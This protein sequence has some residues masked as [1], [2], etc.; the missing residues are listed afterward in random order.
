MF[1]YRVSLN[2][3]IPLMIRDCPLIQKDVVLFLIL[4]WFLS[5]I[6]YLCAN[7]FLLPS[8]FCSIAI[9][10]IGVV[11]ITMQINW[12]ILLRTY[13]RAKDR[14]QSARL[15]VYKTMKSVYT[16]WNT[17]VSAING[18]LLFLFFCFMFYY[19]SPSLLQFW[20]IWIT[21]VGFIVC[22]WSEIRESYT[23]VFMSI[24]LLYRD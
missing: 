22:E 7:G 2:L 20:P 1:S 5:G 23:L 11:M 15:S 6:W 10:C 17:A 18:C 24:H 21:M 3:I 19:Q 12:W 8:L 14:K 4:I 9:G 16:A 13:R